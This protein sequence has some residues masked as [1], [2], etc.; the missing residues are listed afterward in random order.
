M[1]T[2]FPQLQDVCGNGLDD[3]CNGQIDENVDAD[4]DGWGHCDGDCCDVPGS[5]SNTPGLVNP[6]AYEVVGNLVDD[7]CDPATSDTVP[8][9]NCSPGALSTTPTASDLAKSMELCQF[10]TQSPPL[11]QRKWG[12]LAA[13][14]LAADQVSTPPQ[15]IQTGV[16]ANYGPNV[17][18]RKYTTMAALSSG[19]ARDQGDPGWVQPNGGWGMGGYSSP[20][21]VYLAAHNGVLQTKPGCPAGSGAND[22]VNLKLRIRVPTNAKSFSFKF[23]FYSSEYPEWICTQYNDFFLALLTSQVPGIPADHNLSFDALNNPVSVNNGFFQVCS[24]CS[25]GTAELIGTGMGGNNGALTDGGGTL[26]LT[27]TSPIKPGEDMTIEF[28]IFDT[29]DH[30]YD[31]LVLLDDW[32]WD[33]N[34]AEVG[35]TPS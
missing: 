29:S 25:A 27:T 24:G 19:T 16:L 10:T 9:V 17:L 5:C 11:A 23:K 2:Y 21:P 15:A 7:D 8:Q 12:V 22:S 18:P 34:P 31:S 6:G 28:I 3:N 33:L 4:G 30:A 32:K 13:Q 20:P 35:T 14:L 26:W 1:Q